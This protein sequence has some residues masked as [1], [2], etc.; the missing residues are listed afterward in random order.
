MRMTS[1]ERVFAALERRIPDRTPIME[2]IIDPTVVKG[3]GFGSYAEMYEELDLDAVV[4][5]Q[6]LDFPEG[7]K[8]EINTG[9]V[10]TNAWGVTFQYT[11]EVVAIP[12]DHPVKKPE[13]WPNYRPP[14]PTIPEME[15][16]RIREIVQRYK[17]KRAIVAHNRE[18]FG[19]SWNL[20]GMAEYMMDLILHPEMVRQIA[21]VVAAYNKERVRQLI[22]AGVEIILLGDDYAYKTGPFMSPRHFREFLL[23]GMVEIVQYIKHLGAYCIK[24]TDGNIWPIIEEIVGT[25]VDCLGPL[26]PAAGMDLLEVKRR[27]G[28]RVCIMG[29][30]DV[31][32]LSRG[33]PDEVREE[34]A[35]LI[36]RC[37]PGGGYILSSGNSIS[38]SVKPENFLAMIE[39][40][41]LLGV[42]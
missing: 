34:T 38:S 42:Y 25:G 23:P 1:A 28:D 26:E 20:R 10:I 36:T 7:A 4:V 41:R 30:V 18:V 6:L 12:I 5:N 16:R 3:L 39:T 11:H 32:L 2:M 31:D 40:G 37:A 35:R 27:F 22:Q 14:D 17:G 8:L 29:N 24:H 9:K 13:D 33:T 21:E 15:L 19:D